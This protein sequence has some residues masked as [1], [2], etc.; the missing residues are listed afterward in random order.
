MPTD[1]NVSQ[2]A[3][4][5]SLLVGDLFYTLHNNLDYNI[6]T[7]QLAANML[8]N[9][10]LTDGQLI[11]GSS[12]GA[13]LAANILG[14][15]NQIS[16]ANAANSITLSLPQNEE[17]Y[18]HISTLTGIWAS[19]PAITINCSRSGNQV[20]IFIPAITATATSAATITLSDVLPARFRPAN[21]TNKM[22]TIKNNSVQVPGLYVIG[23]DGSITISLY[24]TEVFGNFTGSGT[25]GTEACYISYTV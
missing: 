4:T 21:I 18:S 1:K 6:N 2:L 14:T 9:F 10:A 13:P 12:T 3:N 24:A 11:I 22:E 17:N 16:V 8:S 5:P 19:T 25:S 23:H 20:I 15:T 7:V